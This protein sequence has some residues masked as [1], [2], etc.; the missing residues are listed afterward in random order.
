MPEIRGERVT[1]DPMEAGHAE[2]LHAIRAMPE[3]AERWGQPEDDFPLGDE[4]TATRFAIVAD[5]EVVGMIQFSEENEPDYRHAEMDIFLDPAH[6]GQGLGTDAM[7]AM[8]DHL[9]DARGHHRVVLSVE[10][11]NEPAVRCYEKSGFRRV[12]VTRHSGRN[13]RTGGWSDE[14]FMELVRTPE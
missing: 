4:P 12:G 14:Y 7:V 3:V 5:E 2:R 11:D 13:Y 8:C 10:T 6:H 9:M 1:L